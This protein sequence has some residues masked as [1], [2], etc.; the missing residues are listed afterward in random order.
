MWERFKDWFDDKLDEFLD[1]CDYFYA[2]L[3][4][5]LARH[6]EETKIC[7]LCAG[8]VMFLASLGFMA[9]AAHRALFRICG[10]SFWA[11]VAFWWNIL[12]SVWFGVLASMT[13]VLLV[14]ISEYLTLVKE[15]EW[16][17]SDNE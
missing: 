9:H 10:G 5:P 17:E 12:F 1:E 8:I 14:T 15:Q 3:H 13:Y 11:D 16:R 7:V 2:W 4:R 6:T